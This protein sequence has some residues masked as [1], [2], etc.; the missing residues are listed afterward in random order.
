MRISIFGLGYVGS[1]TAACLAELGHTVIGVEPNPVKIDLIN[2]GH[3]PVVEAGLGKRLQQLTAIGRLRA[4][5]D[6]ESAVAETN[7]AFVC[8]GTPSLQNGNIDLTSVERA[9]THIGSALARRAEYFCVVIRSTV[10]PGSVED[11]VIPAL[12]RASS[13]RAGLDFG[14]CMNPEFLREGTA[15]DD[16]YNPPKTIIGE[17]DSRSGDM[18]EELYKKLPAPIRRVSIRMAE[19]VK[20]ADNA[21][22][23]LKVTFANEIGAISKAAQVDSHRLMEIFCL[24]TKLNLSAYYLKPGFAFGGSCLPKD[25]RALNRLARSMDLETPVLSAILPSNRK[26]VTSVVQQLQEYKPRPLGFLGLSFKSGT[27]DLR[28]SPLVELIENMIGKGFDVRIFDPCVSLSRLMGANKKFI[29]EEIPHISRLICGSAKELFEQ[30]EVIV[31]GHNSEEV[32]SAI[33]LV[34]KRHVV[35]DLVRVCK[36]GLPAAGEYHGICW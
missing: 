5:A 14:V 25:L 10:L 35:I 36:D 16:F 20:Y 24:D 8:V 26:Q 6:W 1:V 4:S 23:A 2:R 21:F 29:E 12:E 9:A 18:L 3:S 7:L 30:A 22:H 11:L 13:K 34:T 32:R 27:D 19:L 15:I 31:V 33:S 28:E 17:L